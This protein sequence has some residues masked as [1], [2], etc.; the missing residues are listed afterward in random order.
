MDSRIESRVGVQA[1]AEVIWDI[2]ADLGGW[3]RWNPHEVQVSGAIAYGG[4]IELTERLPSQAERRVAARVGEWQP[5]AQLVW[6]E[7]RGWL[8]RA[9]RYFEIEELAPGRCIVAN[10]AIFSG[11]RGELF[12]D[13]HRQAIKAAYAEI[14]EG[15]RRA[16]EG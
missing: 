1:D 16:A 3:E 5:M 4:T 11:L 15:L 7:R 10:G 14:G 13:R 2:I 12:H 6:M 9:M 8:F